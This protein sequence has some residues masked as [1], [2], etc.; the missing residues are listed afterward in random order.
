[1]GNYYDCKKCLHEKICD[2]WSKHE[3]Q[4]A[5]SFQLDGCDYYQ[6]KSRYICLDDVTG[7]GPGP[8]GPEGGSGKQEGTFEF[9]L[10]K[11]PDKE[12]CIMCPIVLNAVADDK[13]PLAMWV[14]MLARSVAR[15]WGYVWK[16]EKGA[17]QCEDASGR[18][19]D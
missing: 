6:D 15:I 12:D 1:M 11:L 7:A 14:A 19:N 13:S 16:W 8:R 18:G 10:P 4:D 17:E 3:C 2:L 5:S 9:K